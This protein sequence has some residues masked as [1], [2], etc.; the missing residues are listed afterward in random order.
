[1]VLQRCSA[2]CW[3][4]HASL[5]DMCRRHFEG[6]SSAFLLSRTKWGLCTGF[7][8]VE[9]QP[10]LSHWSTCL[11]RVN[12]GETKPLRHP[13]ALPTGP[14]DRQLFARLF[15]PRFRRIE[16]WNGPD[17]TTDV[18]RGNLMAMSAEYIL[19]LM[20]FGMGRYSAPSWPPKFM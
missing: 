6:V 10:E 15:G 19:S 17:E 4:L 20:E 12:A 11:S 2:V 5:S 8:L 14:R 9:A 3:F 1:M 16:Q 13:P 18:Y 7:Q